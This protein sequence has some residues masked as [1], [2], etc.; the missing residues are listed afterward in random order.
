MAWRRTRA[1]GCTAVSNLCLN[2]FVRA[3]LNLGGTALQEAKQIRSRQK[4]DAAEAR[5]D[6]CHGLQCDQSGAIVRNDIDEACLS[7]EERGAREEDQ[8]GRDVEQVLR[9]GQKF[10]VVSCSDR[11]VGAGARGTAGVRAA[12]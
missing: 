11:W 10:Q 12:Y 1:S 4:R 3:S 5:R 9:Q 2:L 6:T 8:G 7:A